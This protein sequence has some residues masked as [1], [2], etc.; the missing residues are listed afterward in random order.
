MKK[1]AYKVLLEEVERWEE[2]DKNP[3]LPHIDQYGDGLLFE[4]EK[5][6]IAFGT[7]DYMGLATNPLL[8]EAAKKAI[9]DYGTNTYGSQVICGYTKLHRELEKKIVDFLGFSDDER[10][11]VLFP[12]GLHSNIGCISALMNGKDI[13]FC[14]E[15]AHA[16]IFLGIKLSG[17]RC[18]VFKHNNMENLEELLKS[19]QCLGEKYII[20]DGLYSVDGDFA[21]LDRI[22]K[23]A[24]ENQA[25]TF[26]DE[27]HS[28]GIIGKNGRGVAEFYDVL[29]QIDIYTGTMSKGIGSIGGFAVLKRDDAEYVRYF[30]TTYTS[31]RANPPASIAASIA[32]IGVLSSEEGNAMR[33]QLSESSAYLNQELKKIGIMNQSTSHIIPVIIGDNPRTVEVAAFLKKNG[34]HVGTFITPT[35]PVGTARLRIGMASFLKKE[36]CDKLVQLLD[37]AKR[38]YEF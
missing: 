34:I 14:D 20:V 19:N 36:D 28:F 2:D 11:S 32:G 26:V 37:E 24:K 13:V 35:V 10:E 8:K 6:E 17:A 15:Y 5:K 30:A 3:F 18:F 22:I 25:K 27:A 7:C 21:P 38:V 12:S 31:S 9:D 23:L 29:E 16:S 4:D 1:K 33:K